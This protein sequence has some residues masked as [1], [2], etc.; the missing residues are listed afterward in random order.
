FL[1]RRRA[2]RDPLRHEGA[3][4]AQAETAAEVTAE[5]RDDDVV[6]GHHRDD[7]DLDDAQEQHRA[8]AERSEGHSAV[9]SASPIASTSQAG[10]RVGRSVSAFTTAWLVHPSAMIS[11][12]RLISYS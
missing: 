7:H 4:A 1:V 5:Q 3:A 8:E 2:D 11:P 12:S 6:D 10:I 9:A